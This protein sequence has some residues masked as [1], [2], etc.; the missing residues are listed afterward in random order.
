M[1]IHIAYVKPTLVDASGNVIDKDDPAT[2]IQQVANAAATEMRVVPD[3]QVP[4]TLGAP[5]IQ[6]YLNLEDLAGFSVTNMT[7]TTIT[8]EN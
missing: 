7:N 6:A 5:T 1:T 8:T 2:T 4:N 3:P